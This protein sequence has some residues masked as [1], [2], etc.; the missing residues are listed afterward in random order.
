MSIS[1]DKTAKSVGKIYTQTNFLTLKYVTDSW[2]TDANGFKMIVTAFK[3][4]QSNGCRG[5][6]QCDHNIC[7]NNDLVCDT[8]KHCVDGGDEKSSSFCQRK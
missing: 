7:I 2:G 1:C 5:S 4:S 6:F 3:D 8:I